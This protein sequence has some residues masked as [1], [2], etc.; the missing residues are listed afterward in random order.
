MGLRPNVEICL[1]VRGEF[2]MNP[3]DFPPTGVIALKELHLSSKKSF[4]FFGQI[5]SQDNRAPKQD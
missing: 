4:P 1:I 5:L 2:R 3:S